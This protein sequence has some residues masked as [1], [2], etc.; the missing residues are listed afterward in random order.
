MNLI[1]LTEISLIIFSIS[2]LVVTI[3]YI[4]K[5]SFKYYNNTD[6]QKQKIVKTS[7]LILLAASAAF[8]EF[9]VIK[10]VWQLGYVRII[11]EFCQLFIFLS[12]ALILST[13]EFGKKYFNK[14]DA[15]IKIIYKICIFGTLS[16]SALIFFIL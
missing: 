14:S 5:P 8:I 15:K 9:Y 4:K 10:S 1:A 6:G 11:K 7:L 13:L 2:L 12:F 3:L 16:L